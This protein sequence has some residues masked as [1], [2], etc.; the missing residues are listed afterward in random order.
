MAWK[1]LMKTA[2]A[3][4]APEENDRVS[5]SCIAFAAGDGLST[6]AGAPAPHG[7]WSLNLMPPWLESR[8]DMGVSENR[9]P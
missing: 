7:G 4:S 2:E 6:Q 8:Q 9:G 3:P 1:V 5:P